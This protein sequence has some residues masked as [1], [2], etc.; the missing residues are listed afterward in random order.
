MRA[1][2]VDD[3]EPGMSEAV[4]DAWAAVFLSIHDR[5]ESERKAATAEPAIAEV[6]DPD[7]ACDA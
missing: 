1:S 3:A 5:F 7:D 2:P 6:G 4:A